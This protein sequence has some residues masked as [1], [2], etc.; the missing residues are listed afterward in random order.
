MSGF[1]A[2]SL[3]QASWPDFADLVE[4]HNG[5]WGGCWCMAFH[6]EGAGR[7]DPSERDH[8]KQKERLV[9]AGL[10][11]SALVYDEGRCVGWCQYGAPGELPRI[12]CKRAYF[13]DLVDLPD[14][15]ITCFFVDKGYR[16]KGVAA[17]ALGAAL[18]QIASAG[19][20]R[21]ESFPEDTEGRK[22]SASFLHNGSLSMFEAQGFQRTRR[23]GKHRWVV[24]RMVR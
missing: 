14:W 22:V 21:V 15:W 9:Q 4:R 12:K 5:V 2:G 17:A 10:T 6:E 3:D 19:G 23:I 8:R 1:T 24:N 16:R 11:H 7:T 13:D 18:D 20:G